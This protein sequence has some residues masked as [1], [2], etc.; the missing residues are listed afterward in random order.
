MRKAARAII[1]ENGQ[2]LVMY[3]KKQ[4]AEYYT[5]VGGRLQDD[6][7][8]EQA[9]IRE[10]KEETDMTVMSCRLVFT[11]TH[12][13]P[14]NDQYIFLCEVAPHGPVAIRA[15]SEE[16][17]MNRIDINIHKP[18]WIDAKHFAQLSFSTMQLQKAIVEALKEGFP[19]DPI[20]L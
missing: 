12:P 8:P 15:D 5:L 9:L 17:V 11:E 19:D 3:R 1:I 14:Y 18:M 10:V 2:I 20:H 13:E 16:G 6:E 7:T 4:S